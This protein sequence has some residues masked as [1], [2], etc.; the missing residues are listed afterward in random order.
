MIQGQLRID[1][2][3]LLMKNIQG[4]SA[5]I[6][7]CHKDSEASVKASYIIAQKIAAKLKPFTDGELIKECMEAA[8]EILCP[9]QKQLFPN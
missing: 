6:K 2:L 4:Q 3:P 8:S 7:K 5:S 1:K 9:E